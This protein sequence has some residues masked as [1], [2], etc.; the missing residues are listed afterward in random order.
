MSSEHFMLQEQA[1]K[2]AVVK[3]DVFEICYPCTHIVGEEKFL[4]TNLLESVIFRDRN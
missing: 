4:F 2:S 3:S 1:P